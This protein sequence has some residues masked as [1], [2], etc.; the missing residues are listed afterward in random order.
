MQSNQTPTAWQHRV[1][2]THFVVTL[3]LF[4]H[5]H[6]ESF[7]HLHLL[8]TDMRTPCTTNIPTIQRTFG[9]RSD[10]MR[11]KTAAPIRAPCARCATASTCCATRSMFSRLDWRSQQKNQVSPIN[12][13]PSE[14]PI[15]QTRTKK[16][17]HRKNGPYAFRTQLYTPTIFCVFVCSF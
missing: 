13:T 8:H 11:T 14:C 6:V 9:A 3:K 7:A 15:S 1:S 10:C 5:R 16:T 12:L 17:S 4:V 2:E